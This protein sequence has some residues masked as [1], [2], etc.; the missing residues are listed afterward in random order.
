[1]P[2]PPHYDRHSLTHQVVKT[3]KSGRCPVKA[4]TDLSPFIYEAGYHGCSREAEMLENRLMTLIDVQVVKVG[5]AEMG[6]EGRP[7]QAND[8]NVNGMNSLECQFLVRDGHGNL[9]LVDGAEPDAIGCMFDGT[10]M[11]YGPSNLLLPL[12][13]TP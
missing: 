11:G 1:M 4:Q 5:N 2:S 7:Q 8:C 12:I 10:C 6:L 9:M 13:L 3:G